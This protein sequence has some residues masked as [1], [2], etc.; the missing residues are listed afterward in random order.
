[1]IYEELIAKM[2]RL[3]LDHCIRAL[4]DAVDLEAKSL[5]T[6]LT[7]YR[8]KRRTTRLVEHATEEAK[9][10]YVQDISEYL[11]NPGPI[12]PIGA[13]VVLTHRRLP[14]AWAIATF[15]RDNE[16]SGQYN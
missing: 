2:S 11:A 13:G 9:S 3:R 15:I 1:M 4:E 7:T 5:L 10:Y 8:G 16:L 6:H 14:T 12:P